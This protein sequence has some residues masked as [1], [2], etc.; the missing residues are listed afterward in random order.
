MLHLPLLLPQEMTSYQLMRLS[1]GE[2]L[3]NM[4]REMKMTQVQFS[5]IN[6]ACKIII[7][8]STKSAVTISASI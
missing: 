4:C 7:T 5:I 6:T 2:H 1:A 8:Q 3:L